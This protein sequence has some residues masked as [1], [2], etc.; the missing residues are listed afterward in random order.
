MVERP[1]VGSGDLRR[2]P[3][4]AARAVTGRSRVQIPAG[5]PPSLHVDRRSCFERI[6]LPSEVLSKSFSKTILAA[7]ESSSLAIVFSAFRASRRSSSTLSASLYRSSS[8]E[9]I[10]I[11]TNLLQTLASSRSLSKSM[12]FSHLA[13][14]DQTVSANF[15]S[16]FSSCF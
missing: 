12:Q 5:G 16:G 6:D 8:P 14:S 10:P 1:A 9:R 11:L 4:A 3:S 2:P 15:R 7:S 13:S